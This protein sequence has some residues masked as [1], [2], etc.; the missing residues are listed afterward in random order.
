MGM[1]MPIPQKRVQQSFCPHGGADWRFAPT[2]PSLGGG[3]L[4]SHYTPGSLYKK[5]GVGAAHLGHGHAHTLKKGATVF[6][7]PLGGHIGGLPPLCLPLGGRNPT[8]HKGVYI[9][10]VGVGAVHHGHVHALTPKKGATVFLP[11]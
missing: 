6:L 7:S 11:P 3:G 10:K 5:V 2:L 9:K 1:A 8:R 4:K